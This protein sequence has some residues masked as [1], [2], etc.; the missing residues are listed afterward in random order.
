VTRRP[1]RPGFHQIFQ[2]CTGNQAAFFLA[3]LAIEALQL[4]GDGAFQ[5]VEGEVRIAVLTFAQGQ[6]GT[7]DGAAIQ[8]GT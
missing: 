1:Q 5:R 3:V 8:G 4:G 7:G 6:P 2:Q